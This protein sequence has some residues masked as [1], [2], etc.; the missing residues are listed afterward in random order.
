M[1]KL[2]YMQQKI[3]D[4]EKFVK[5]AKPT[6]LKHAKELLKAFYGKAFGE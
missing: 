4:Y 2:W 6:H 5:E 1:K 3:G